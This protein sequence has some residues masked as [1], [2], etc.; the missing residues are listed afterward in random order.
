MDLRHLHS[1]RGLDSPRIPK[2]SVGMK[3]S[4]ETVTFVWPDDV[5]VERRRLVWHGK[6]LS[7]GL[8][9]RAYEIVSNA[10]DAALVSVP[11]GRLVRRG[12]WC[13]VTW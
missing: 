6:L 3:F 8:R 12:D 4:S 7:S 2:E 1:Q 10:G 9:Y 5:Q 13:L 11:K